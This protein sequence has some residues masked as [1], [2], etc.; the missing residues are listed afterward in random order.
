MCERGHG[1]GVLEQPAQ[2]GVV[3]GAG[4]RRA[5]PGLP[6]DAVGHQRVE[7]SAVALVVDLARQVLEEAVKLVEVTI[8]AREKYARIGLAV[9]AGYVGD[10]EHGVAHRGS[11]RRAPTREPGRRARNGRPGDQHFETPGL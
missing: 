10:L 11:A 1:D 4:G 2:V 6:Q 7:Q 5:A 3:S 8:G 9:L